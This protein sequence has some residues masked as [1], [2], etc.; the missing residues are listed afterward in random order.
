MSLKNDLQKLCK[1]QLGSL[2]TKTITKCLSIVLEL[3]EEEW[4]FQP[5][6]QPI[7]GDTPSKM[8]QEDLMQSVRDMLISMKPS[9]VFHIEFESALVTF[10]PS[11]A[12]HYQFWNEGTSAMMA[13]I[14]R[15]LWCISIRP[16][17][18]GYTVQLY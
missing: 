15:Y 14:A 17:H 3:E 7:I 4:T 8:S 6:Q 1:R 13:H 18:C 16:F 12:A 5:S 9:A 10:N 2:D 11:V